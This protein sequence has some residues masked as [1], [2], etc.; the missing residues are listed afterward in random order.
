MTATSAPAHELGLRPKDE[1]PED[2]RWA[3]G[4]TLL[5]LFSVALFDQ[6]ALPEVS[7]ALDK[8]GR[9]RN[10]PFGRA[11]RTAASH[12]LIAWGHGE[13]RL[14]EAER[15]KSLHR[16]VRGATKDG[17]PYSAFTPDLWRFIQASSIMM[18]HNGVEVL[19][20][21]SLSPEEDRAFYDYM[22]TELEPLELGPGAQLPTE[23]AEFVDWYEQMTNRLEPTQTLHV[24]LDQMRRAPTPDFLPAPIHPLWPV[25]RPVL[26]HVLLVLGTGAMHPRARGA[27]QLKWGRAE[28]AQFTLLSRGIGIAYRH[29]PKRAT[30][31]PLAYNRWR[32]EQLI[33][34]YRSVGLESF[35]SAGRTS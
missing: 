4:A 10:D 25:A 27:L 3:T 35:A 24:A 1:L 6:A 21:R 17:Q 16:V 28:R 26:G 5:G 15:L 22:L 33:H 7:F 14:A 23:W 11:G 18:I 13:D 19:I 32:Y 34:Q 2:I 20:G 8:T 9:I 29:L 12:Q 31:S 30:L